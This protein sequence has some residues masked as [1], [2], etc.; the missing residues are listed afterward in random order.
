MESNMLTVQDSML[1][2]V[3]VCFAWH[4]NT[5]H[6]ENPGYHVELSGHGHCQYGDLTP[7]S[8]GLSWYAFLYRYA[9][10]NMDMGKLGMSAEQLIQLAHRELET[11]AIVRLR[12][13]HGED[14]NAN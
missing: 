10:D 6:M 9:A 1:G 7:D 3:Q 5:E 13:A 4:F 8:Q 2:P 14:N 11:V 12:L